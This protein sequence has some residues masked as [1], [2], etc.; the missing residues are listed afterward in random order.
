MRNFFEI[1]EQHVKIFG[2]KKKKCLEGNN[3]IIKHLM[4]KKDLKSVTDRLS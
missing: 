2:V 3:Y 1:N 4:I